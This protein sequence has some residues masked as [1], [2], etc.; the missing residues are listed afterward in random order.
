MSFGMVPSGEKKS[1]ARSAFKL[2][3]RWLVPF[4]SSTVVF[5]FHVLFLWVVG[6]KF[7]SCLVLCTCSTVDRRTD[8]QAHKH[9]VRQID[10]QTD[11]QTS[12]QI[13]AFF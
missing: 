6:I 4:T 9:T 7:L 2:F 1:L 3:C 8:R 10:K 13:S 5:F 12:E 11:S